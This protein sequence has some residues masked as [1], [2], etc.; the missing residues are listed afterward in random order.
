M[1]E[2]TKN[3]KKRKRSPSAKSAISGMTLRP[4]NKQRRLNDQCS[5]ITED[6]KLDEP[7]ETGASYIRYEIIEKKGK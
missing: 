5:E 4:R 7:K 1:K 6:I 3:P 2:E